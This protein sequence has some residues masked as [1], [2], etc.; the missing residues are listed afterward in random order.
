[1]KQTK[2]L[3]DVRVG[4]AAAAG[5]TRVM[6][7]SLVP[8]THRPTQRLVPVL[9]APELIWIGWLHWATEVPAQG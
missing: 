6:G 2:Q 4:G 8:S 3:S 5:N 1:M 7:A 9:P